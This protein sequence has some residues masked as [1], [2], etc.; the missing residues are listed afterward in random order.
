MVQRKVKTVAKK[1]TR[2][3]FAQLKKEVEGAGL[4]LTLQR[5]GG[6][7]MYAIVRK[8]EIDGEDYTKEIAVKDNHGVRNWVEGAKYAAAN[9]E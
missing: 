4:D 9:A 8:V 7:G 6:D 3:G 1:K 5:G 2:F